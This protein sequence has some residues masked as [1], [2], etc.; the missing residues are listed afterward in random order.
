MYMQS[1]GHRDGQDHSMDHHD[2]YDHSM[3]HHN[4][5]DRLEAGGMYDRSTDKL[6]STCFVRMNMG[7]G[8]DMDTDMVV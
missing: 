5:Y 2:V 7:M 8:T 4:V 6:L 3:G 1:M